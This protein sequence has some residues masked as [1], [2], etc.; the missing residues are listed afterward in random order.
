[1][2][3]DDPIADAVSA[4]LESQQD[5]VHEAAGQ[6]RKADALK[7]RRKVNQKADAK[8]H[9]EAE[10]HEAATARFTDSVTRFYAGK[11]GWKKL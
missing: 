4:A 11:K 10:R 3:S 5:G 8:Q 9:A 2:S 7:E 6:V 1:M